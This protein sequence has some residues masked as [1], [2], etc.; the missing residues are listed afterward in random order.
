[1][2]GDFFKGWASTKNKADKRAEFFA[3]HVAKFNGY[4]IATTGVNS[5]VWATCQAGIASSS[6]KVLDAA[7]SAANAGE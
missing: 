6:S 1:M 5:V 4:N 7:G 2:G 3:K